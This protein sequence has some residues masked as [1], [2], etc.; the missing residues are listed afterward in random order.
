MVGLLSLAAL[1][2]CVSQRSALL[3]R[4]TCSA[5][6][7]SQVTANDEWVVVI[8]RFDGKRQAMIGVTADNLTA[9]FP[10]ISTAEAQKEIVT[11]GKKNL[12]RNMSEPSLL[13]CAPVL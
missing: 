4:S 2:R 5:P 6:Y 8:E 9:K 13:R 12:N 10:F 1:D 11:Y 3:A 7:D